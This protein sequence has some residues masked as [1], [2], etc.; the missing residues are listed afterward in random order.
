[1][2]VMI[3]PESHEGLEKKVW[4][5]KDVCWMTT[6][7]WLSRI[8]GSNCMLVAQTK[9]PKNPTNGMGNYWLAELEAAGKDLLA[10]I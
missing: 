6:R 3:E 10:N 5:A 1:M 9:M 8:L 7:F 2:L 4:T